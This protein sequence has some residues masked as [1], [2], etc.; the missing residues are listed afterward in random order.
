MGD[1][2]IYVGDIV[3][4]ITYTDTYRKTGAKLYFLRVSH[5]SNKVAKMKPLGTLVDRSKMLLAPNLE[6]YKKQ[7][8][9]DISWNAE[10][11]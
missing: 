11:N 6:K 2:K 9:S 7:G 10:G 4:F 3:Y 5:I 1:S 8:F